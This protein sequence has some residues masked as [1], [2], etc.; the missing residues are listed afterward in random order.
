ML[1]ALVLTFSLGAWA[2]VA[3]A[4]LVIAA[5]RGRLALVTTA[6]VGLG[7]LLTI[8]L[9]SLWVPRIGSH[10][11]LQSSTSAIRLD[12]WRSGINML[13][14]HPIRGIGLDNFLYYYQHGYRLPTAWQD[15]NLSHPHNVLLDFWLSLGLPG[16]ILL[17]ALVVRFVSRA[18][19]AWRAS[20]P[21]E[22]GLVA[23]VV[24]ALTATL[25]HGV[26]DN[27]FFLPDLAV[28]F[29][30]MFVIFGG[31]VEPDKP[32]STV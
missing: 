30:V 19:I 2:A 3:G 22:R 13:A 1:G 7:S 9:A 23:G 8:A 26:V 14:D 5:L 12:V 32:S 25:L 16:P 10:F 15:P 31:V 29:W 18:T 20:G 27:S 24:G 4:A 17:G 28:L 21:T 11:D 6:I